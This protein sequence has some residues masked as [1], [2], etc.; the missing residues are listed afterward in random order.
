VE[1]SEDE[2]DDNWHSLP[3]LE[4]QSEDYMCDIASEVSGVW[5]VNQV[6]DQHLTRQKRK[7]NRKLQSEATP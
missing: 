2:E 6:L 7:G 4:M 3:L 1:L 5:S